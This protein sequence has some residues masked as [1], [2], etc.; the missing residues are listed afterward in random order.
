MS[1][2]PHKSPGQR[3]EELA[4]E[5]WNPY[6]LAYALETGAE[7]PRQAFER[8]GGNHEFFVWNGKRWD[9][10]CAMIGASREYCAVYYSDHLET[11]AARILKS[12]SAQNAEP[13]EPTLF[14]LLP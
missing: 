12:L 7:T 6:Y 3:L 10:T 5:E 14:D 1:K 9:E 8:D 2:S 13:T 11:L 4:G